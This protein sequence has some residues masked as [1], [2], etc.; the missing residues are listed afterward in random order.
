MLQMCH[1]IFPG[2]KESCDA[3]CRNCR[4]QEYGNDH[5]ILMCP[6]NKFR[7][8]PPQAK[9]MFTSTSIRQGQKREH[10]GGLS[11]NA[12]IDQLA[13]VVGKVYESVSTLPN[14]SQS[15]PNQSAVNSEGQVGAKKKKKTHEKSKEKKSEK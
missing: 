14:L 2:H 4:G 11:T 13:K 3:K 8:C 12:R 10:D 15:V 7:S 9:K 6:R 1:A 5:Y